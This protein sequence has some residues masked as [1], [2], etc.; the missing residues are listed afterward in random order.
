MENFAYLTRELIAKKGAIEV[1][2]AAKL[3]RAIEALLKD[4]V[5]RQSLVANA[6][7]VL[8]RHRGASKRTTELIT[9]FLQGS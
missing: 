5:A 8:A 3:E 1:R 4:P 7:Q 2:D 9:H 6:E